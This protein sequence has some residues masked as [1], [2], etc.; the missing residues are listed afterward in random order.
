[1]R[2]ADM[3]P[4]GGSMT[5]TGREVSKT[6][7]GMIVKSERKI[8]EG[9]EELSINRAVSEIASEGQVGRSVVSNA[10]NLL[11]DLEL[12]LWPNKDSEEL[13]Y[14][15]IDCERPPMIGTV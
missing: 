7:I 6:S 8:P 5:T 15:V 1:M 10:C 3:A 14:E 13:K 4:R 11:Q 2:T 9:L 12:E